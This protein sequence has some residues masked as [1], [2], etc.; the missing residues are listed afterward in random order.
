M[1]RR[2]LSRIPLALPLLLALGGATAA[3]QPAGVTLYS[4]RHLTGNHETF[5]GHVPDLGQTSFGSDRASSISVAPGCVAILYEKTHYRGRSTTFREVDNDLGNTFVG[6]DRASSLQVRCER[7]DV[8]GR[9]LE[10]DRGGPHARPGQR[11]GVTLFRDRNLRGP[12][13]TFYEDVP[14]LARTRLGTDRASSIG[15]PPGCVAVLY[16]FPHYRGRSTTFRDNDNNLRNTPVGEDSVSSMKIHC[17]SEEGMEH[18]RPRP[19]DRPVREGSIGIT[20]FRDR[21]LSGPHE[22][23]YEDMPDLSQTSIGSRTASSIGV[24]R[25]CI[26]ILYEFPHFRG[27]STTFRDSDNN[28]RNTLVGEDSVS[29]MKVQCIRP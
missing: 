23:F 8:R 29:S 20:L 19:P 16:Q 11:P 26:A 17:G 15:V 10:G 28:L 24:P 2:R 6:D 18:D 25:G 27:R 12:S 13:Q 14:D 22:T 21:N 4:G 7:S 9:D 5:Y 3:A 1:T